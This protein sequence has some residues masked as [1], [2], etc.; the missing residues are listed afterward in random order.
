MSDEEQT[1]S[2]TG[3]PTGGTP[4]G[5]QP[6]E[7]RFFG[8][9][10]VDHSG[11]Y[12]L[13]RVGLAAGS[14]AAAVAACFVLRFAYEGLQIAAVGGIVNMLVVIMFAVCSAIAFRKTWEGYLRRPA[15]PAREESLRSLKMIGFIGAL[16]AYCARCFVE[17]PGEK[18][19]RAE[20][21]TARAQFEKRRGAR[22]GNPAARKKPKRK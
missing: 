5:P 10:W 12:T 21:E 2:P 19:R 11:N 9:T 1:P 8:T 16:L 14:L 4:A 22:T 18:L 20:Y 15:D 17:A 6:E 13:R 3:G 7:V